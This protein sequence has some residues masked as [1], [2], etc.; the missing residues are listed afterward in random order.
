MFDKLKKLFVV[1]DPNAVK[2]IEGQQ[3]EAAVKEAR[4]SVPTSRIEIDKSEASNSPDPKFIDILLKAIDKNNMDGFDYLEFKQTLQG[5]ANVT[6]DESTKYSSALAMARTMGSSKDVILKSAGHYLDVLKR[7]ESKFSE[8]LHAQ[9][10]KIE[11]NQTDGLANLEKSIAQKKAQVEKLLSEI[12][13]DEANLLAKKDEISQD[14][15]KL[16]TTSSNFKG[17]YN[18][19]ANQ[20]IE[21]AEKI[22]NITI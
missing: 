16:Q 6:M 1:E 11:S 18:L 9:R 21:D 17:A 2:D 7:E 12:K 3:T 15:E 20:I 22:K 8:A 13:N 4:T 14:A 10:L 19:V 5:L